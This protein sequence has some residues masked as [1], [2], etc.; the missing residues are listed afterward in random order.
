M[1][2]T[3]LLSVTNE[4]ISTPHAVTRPHLPLER[5]LSAPLS[6]PTHPRPV[7]RTTSRSFGYF[8]LADW[9]LLLWLWRQPA[10]SQL[11]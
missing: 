4:K 1:H 6:R 8:C 7:G 2:S 5:P 9:L 3:G 10:R 11:R